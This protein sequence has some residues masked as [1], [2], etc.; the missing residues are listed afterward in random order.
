[1]LEPPAGVETGDLLITNQ[2]LGST[3]I[4]SQAR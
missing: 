4:Y 2:F 3:A 1:M